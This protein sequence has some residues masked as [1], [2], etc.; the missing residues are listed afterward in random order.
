MPWLT[1]LYIG[2]RHAIVDGNAI[3]DTAADAITELLVGISVL[4]ITNNALS[5]ACIVRIRAQLKNVKV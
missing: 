4:G 2:K 1:T 3:G 5:A